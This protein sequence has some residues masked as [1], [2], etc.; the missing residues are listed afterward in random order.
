MP[1]T[2]TPTAVP[3]PTAA[4]EPEPEDPAQPTPATPGDA[5]S[6]LDVVVTFSGWNDLSGAV[7]VG[8]YVPVVEDDGTCTL[9]L[10]GG[11]GTPT[12][13]SDG[14]P[15]ASSTSCGSLT[16]PGSAVPSGT[17]TATV[18]Y[19]SSTSTGSSD[20]VTVEVP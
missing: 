7:E 12:A 20:P 6:V 10:T 8:A 4:P 3:E 15:D 13:T 19:A 18:T 2:A 9:T 1:P 11:S 17:W 16:L 14:I 5:A